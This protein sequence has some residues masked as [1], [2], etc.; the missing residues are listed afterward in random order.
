MTYV[1]YSLGSLTTLRNPKF[2]IRRRCIFE[3][4]VGVSKLPQ[5]YIQDSKQHANAEYSQ[6]AFDTATAGRKISITRRSERQTTKNNV[7]CQLVCAN[8]VYSF[9]KPSDKLLNY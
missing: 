8:F 4:T 3:Y 5:S 2:A 7:Q 9:W 6:R 1:A